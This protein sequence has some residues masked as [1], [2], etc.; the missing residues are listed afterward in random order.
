MTTKNEDYKIYE[1]AFLKQEKE[2]LV[3][4][5]DMNGG[6]RK[7]DNSWVCIN[8][9]LAYVDTEK[10]ELHK[11]DGSITWLISDEQYGKFGIYWPYNFN[12]GAIYRLKVRELKDKTIPEGFL[13]SVANELMIVKVFEETIQNKTLIDILNEYRKPVI[14]SDSELGEFVL[15]KDLRMFTG[16]IKWLGKKVSVHL[17][18]QVDNQA[19]WTKA[20]NNLRKLYLVQE[21]YDLEL[22]QFVVDRL[23]DTANS[24]QEEVSKPKLTQNEFKQ[25]ISLS[26]LSLNSSKYQFDFSD[27]NIFRGH[28]IRISGNTKTGPKRADIAG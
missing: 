12:Q 7:M 11:G 10:N 15:N 4:T 9:I 3:L 6:A 28:T 14:I 24:W 23:L 2:V 20:M 25:R 19:S 13:P 26:G 22:R 18:V 5:C 21:N 16:T 8:D 17:D 27:D 1:K